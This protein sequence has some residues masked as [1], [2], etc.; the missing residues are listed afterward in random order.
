VAELAVAR[1]ARAK[2]N[3]DLLVI[4]R[5]ADGYH[6]LDSLVV[7]A[8]AHDLLTAEPAD[9]LTLVVEGPQAASVPADDGNLVLAA[10]RSLARAAGVPPRAA[11]RLV[12]RLPVAAGLGGGS[13]D[14]AATLQALDRLWGL[15]LG[16]PALR[17]IGLLLGADVPVCLGGRPARL[18][19]IGE[20]L[21]PLPDLPDLPL[22]LVN[23]G[24]PVATASV[25]RAL[26]LDRA[27]APRGPMPP[28]PSLGAVAAWLAA[29]RN[30]L[31]APAL[32]IAPAIGEAL[33]LLRALPG[34]LVARMSGSGASCW[35]LFG[36]AG[37]LARAEARLAASRGGW[38][39]W[40]GLVAGGA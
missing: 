10:A 3:L 24:V 27:A 20:R 8:G 40:A 25:F 37:E 31:E 13:A 30:D 15:G 14:A 22:L 16:E 19:G 29:G 28:S 39:R 2:V 26:R 9:A 7:F 18:R 21:D 5:R 34:C 11:L 23:P 35:A 6:E 1:R 4:G 32:A 17:E 38:W 36:T 12:K 33:A